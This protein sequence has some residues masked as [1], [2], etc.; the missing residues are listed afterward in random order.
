MAVVRII[1]GDPQAVREVGADSAGTVPVAPGQRFEVMGVAPGDVR[2]QVVGD[3]LRLDLNDGTSVTLENFVLYLRQG[4]AGVALSLG[5]GGTVSVIDS[6]DALAT[7]QATPPVGLPLLAGFNTAAGGGDIGEPAGQVETLK[8][9]VTAVRADGS[10]VRLAVGDPV[11]QGDVL[12]T[13]PGGAVGVLLLDE[14][15]FSMSENGRIVLD[16]MIYDPGASKGSLVL[17]LVQGVFT[18]V[19]GQVAK[20]D[21]DAMM[22]STPIAT[23]GIRGTQIGVDFADA[24]TLTV[25]NMVESDGF[26][27]E[28][29]ITTE[30]GSG[31]IN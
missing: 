23:I 10:Q 20:T 30:A 7:Y 16:E 29:L 1:G 24:E 14:T 27:G 12:Q 31:V 26:V 28:V 17:S 25:V 18:F 5:D 11:Y 6:L 21:P 8:G 15:T 2:T 19:S 13:G 4:D 3:D 22:L 9:S